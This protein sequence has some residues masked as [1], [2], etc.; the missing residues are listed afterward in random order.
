MIRT[1]P[2][3]TFTIDPCNVQFIFQGRDPNINTDY[4]RLPYRLGLITLQ[5]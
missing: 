1:N 3:E 5:R 2:D 4:G